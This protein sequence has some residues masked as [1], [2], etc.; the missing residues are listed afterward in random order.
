MRLKHYVDP[1]RMRLPY[2]LT[3]YGGVGRGHVRVYGSAREAREREAATWNGVPR[4]VIRNRAQSRVR[5]LLAR[6]RRRRLDELIALR[7]HAYYAGMSD[8]YRRMA[9]SARSR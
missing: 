3:Y 6:L 7:E 2:L 4:W 9:Q 1:K 5:A 8:E